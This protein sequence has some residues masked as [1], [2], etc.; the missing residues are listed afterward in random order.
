MAKE[1]VTVVVFKDNFAARSFKVPLGWVSRLGAGVGLLL[2][3]TALVSLVAVK[4]YRI[5]HQG[6]PA[7]IGSLEEEIHELQTTNETLQAKAKAALD[8]AAAAV[9]NVAVQPQ[10]TAAPVAV[11]PVTPPPT[12][13]TAKAQAVPITAGNVLLFR[14]LP[15][16]V[17]APTDPAAI[18]ISV[19]TP[20]VTWKGKNLGV[21][22]AIQYSGQSGG[23]QQGRIVVIARGPSSMLSYPDTVFN[24]GSSATL[25]APEQGEYFSVSRYRET[26]AEFTG[27]TNPA[28]L[29]EVEIL[30]FGSPAGVSDESGFEL[31]IHQR[32][33]IEAAPK[34]LPRPK[35]K[36]V[37][38]PAEPAD[39]SPDDGAQSQPATPGAQDTN[40]PPA[41]T[42]PAQPAAPGSQ[43]PAQPPASASDPAKTEPAPELVQ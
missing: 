12:I 9:K 27:I 26:H 35:P 19:V 37:A 2:L 16:G 24:L 25:I 3:S 41:A 13:P 39:D 8:A 40:E 7:R 42:E 20:K 28:S 43:A 38:K 17:L 29:K 36:P 14:D 10:P 6:D 1:D 23:N 15:L 22:F 18:P 34:V 30:I 11:Q 32:V 31:L 4:Y 21:R 33:P 5:A